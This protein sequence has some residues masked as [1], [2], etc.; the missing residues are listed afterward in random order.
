MITN[1]LFQERVCGSRQKGKQ[2]LSAE[3]LNF[4]FSTHINAKQPGLVLPFSYILIYGPLCPLILIYAIFEG[5][6][7]SSAMNYPHKNKL[8]HKFLSVGIAA[9]IEYF[10]IYEGQLPQITRQIVSCFSIIHVTSRLSIARFLVP[11]IHQ[12]LF[13]FYI[14]QFS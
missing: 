11:E 3:K 4:R 13:G 12:I 8:K 5:R 1:I 10:T 6:Q 14:I 7:S 2:P 9:M